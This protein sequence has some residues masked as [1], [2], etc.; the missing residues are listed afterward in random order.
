MA[1]GP[2]KGGTILKGLSIGKIENHCFKLKDLPLLSALGASLISHPPEFH[3][4]LEFPGSD[5]FKFYI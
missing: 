2:H 5:S 3:L 4:T 1:G